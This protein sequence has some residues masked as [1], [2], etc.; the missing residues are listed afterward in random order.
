MARI[1]QEIS[2]ANFGKR[3]C[4]L[5]TYSASPL[6]DCMPAPPIPPFFPPAS[7]LIPPHLPSAAEYRLVH[8]SGPI[9][10]RHTDL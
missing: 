6:Y 3:N 1:A 5:P 4:P 2:G 10:R 7:L 9:M 8:V